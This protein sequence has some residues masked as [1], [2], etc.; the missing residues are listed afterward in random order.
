MRATRLVN[1]SRR[2]RRRRALVAAC[3]VCAALVAPAAAGAKLP[4]IDVSNHQG[5]IDWGE[6]ARSGERFAIVK[7]SES[8][9]FVDKWYESNRSGAD[10]RDVKLGAYHYARPSGGKDSHIADDA[11]DEAKH[12]LRIAKPRSGDLLPML[13]LEDAGSLNPDELRYW[14]KKWLRKVD[15][16]V[17]VKPMIYTYPSF[18]HVQ[19]DN[20]QFFAKRGYEALFIANYEVKRPDVPADNW[21]GEGWTFW[22]YTSCGKV[23][24]IKGCVDRDFYKHKSFN[25]V[26]IP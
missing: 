8:T 11:K 23:P 6:V 25:R 24:G 9:N 18:W 17:G 21:D 20:T 13:D 22:Q 7:A 1:R 12:F 15:R 16:E 4:G 10:K 3:A 5:E 19:M 2:A 26:E 14:A